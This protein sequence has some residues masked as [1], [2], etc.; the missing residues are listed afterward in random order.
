MSK[1][2]RLAGILGTSKDPDG[3][4]PHFRDIGIPLSQDRIRAWESFPCPICY[5]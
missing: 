5:Y 1:S 2:A 3:K 4:L